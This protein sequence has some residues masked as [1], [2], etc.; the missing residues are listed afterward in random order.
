PWVADRRGYDG[1]ESEAVDLLAALL[2]ERGLTEARV[3]AELGHEQRLGVSP[4]GFDRLRAL[5]PGVAWR[6][7]APL[8]WSLRARKSRGEVALL[9]RAGAATA[10]AYRRALAA[11]RVGVSEIELYRAF[12]I[13][14]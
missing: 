14:A 13:G 9:R 2:R 11:V 12:A 6:D 4:L 3:G 7:A 5:V 1:S 10:Q 8:L